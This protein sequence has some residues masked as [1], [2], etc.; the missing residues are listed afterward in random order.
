MSAVLAA[1]L[2]V[3]V[4]LGA[5]LLVGGRHLERIA[6]PTAITGAVVTASLAS[7]AAAARASLSVPSLP[8]GATSSLRVDALAAAMLP[9]VTVIAVLVLV[10]GQGDGTRPAARFNGLMLVFLGAVIVTIVATD[11]PVLLAGWEVMGATSYALIG[12]R[13]QQAWRVGDGAVAFLATRAGDLGLY[14]AAGAAL[15]SGTGWRLDTLSSADGP[16]LQVIAAG[17]LAAGLGKA[18]QLPFSFWISHAMAGPS[19]VSALLH[20]AAM[21]AMGG[22]LL[23]RAE[24]L[25]AATVWAGPVAAWLGVATA[26]V[27]GVVALAQTDLKQALAAST[28]AQLGFVVMA[29]GVGAVTGGT[30]Q[31][32]AH[33]AT[34]AALFLAA[35]AWLTALGTKQFDGLRGVARRWPA[36]GIA[37]TAAALSLAGAPPLSL[38]VAKDAVLA[39]VLAHSPGLYAA[40]LVA[41]ALSAAYS[42]RIIA[43][44]W[45]PAGT[46]E[47]G[48]DTEED[49]TRRI[50]AIV[51]LPILVLSAF[52]VVLGVLALPAVRRLLPDDS[53]PAPSWAELTASGGIAL[54]ILVLVFVRIPGI[55]L[56]S[57]WFRA[58]AVVD[59]LVVAPVRHLSVVLAAADDRYAA[60]VDGVGRLGRG[61]ASGSATA[62]AGLAR[63][64]D[65]I[66]SGL[67]STASGSAAADVGL[68]RTV[69][70]IAVGVSRAGRAARRTQTGHVHDY[71]IAAAVATVVAV[72]VL[73]VSR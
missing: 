53:A 56:G 13:W 50:G 61:A 72:A 11:L 23:L 2:A 1:A 18:A 8:A 44:L 62:D 30:M 51:Q 3:P 9:T 57:G 63:T 21:V 73:L 24:P 64:V 42:G 65:A 7:I 6:A 66:G 29:A 49:G 69:G 19:A 43:L 67:S 35:G 70:A 28:A 27:L 38:W 20:S 48:W 17:F 25:L 16:W 52:A 26:V 36:V 60:A 47:A 46:P 33:A 45:R 39:G 59:R 5:I 32:L 4:T 31:L 10:F 15:A 71:Y 55:R 34:K 41:A 14:L 22:Y 37:A 54:L 12:F 68:A 40:A 58:D